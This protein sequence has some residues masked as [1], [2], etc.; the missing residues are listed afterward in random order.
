[1]L[2]TARNLGYSKSMRIAVLLFCFIVLSPV[3]G[4]LPERD[5]PWRE[6]ILIPY[7]GPPRKPSTTPTLHKAA[8]AGHLHT[9]Q[10]ELANGESLELA[11][12]RGYTA[13]HHAAFRGHVEVVQYLLSKGALVDAQGSSY[14][15]P[16]ILAA[17]NGHAEVVGLL[18]EGEAELNTKSG[19]GMTALHKAAFNGHSDVV[20]IL[21]ENGADKTLLDQR[22]RTPL[23]LA[24]K[25]RQGEWEQTVRLLKQ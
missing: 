9:V 7:E 16:L 5:A 6:N 19:N 25:Y 15:T 12:E 13:L 23:Q 8:A 2:V 18:V 14:N 21:L 22:R 11:D 1:M 4:Q 20:E 17:A 24:E 3:W 10:L